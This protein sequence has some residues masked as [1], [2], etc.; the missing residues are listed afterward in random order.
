[1]DSL[2]LPVFVF[3]SCHA[4]LRGQGSDILI[5][6]EAAFIDK[7]MIQTVVA[8]Q[9]ANAV[10]S[11]L[12]ISSPMDERNHYSRMIRTI[13]PMTNRPL[14]YVIE[15]GTK[16]K[17]CAKNNEPD[18][19][20]T[21]TRT[22][23]WKSEQALRRIE[24]IMTDKEMKNREMYGLITS[25]S[26]YIFEP[27]VDAF[28]ELEPYDWDRH[29]DALHLA[30]DPG[31]GGGSDYSYVLVGHE[32]ENDIIVSYGSIAGKDYD[33]VVEAFDNF[34]RDLR[35][36]KRYKDSLVYVYVEVGASWFEPQRLYK[37]FLDKQHHYGRIEFE[38]YKEKD[39]RAT[40]GFI[41]TPEMKERLVDVTLSRIKNEQLR[42]C[43]HLAGADSVLAQNRAELLVQLKEY[44]CELKP[45]LDSSFGHEKRTFTG[46]SPGQKDDLCMAL[47]MA[48]YYMYKTQYDAEV[49]RADAPVT[50]IPAMYHQQALQAY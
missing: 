13:D 28:A 22:P 43:R 30:I 46:K 6:E 5:L 39:G 48:L 14:F 42:L 20:H 37:R 17:D 50:L 12:G 19:A 38:M 24:L 2:A 31:G 32:N 4:G 49:A 41:M 26:N 45:A 21:T 34:W 35:K 7:Q 11:V 1:L 27:Y 15:V 33:L 44:R 10:Y 16:C 47:Q 40:P 8:P 25:A 3:C 18:C 29:P 9:M 36:Q 23:P